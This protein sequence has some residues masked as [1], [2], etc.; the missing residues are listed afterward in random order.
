M[1]FEYRANGVTQTKTLERFPFGARDFSCTVSPGG[2]RSASANFTD[3]WTGDESPNAGWGLTLFHI[4]DGIFAI[5]YTYDLDGEPTFFVL[6]TS[7]QPDDSFS[8]TIFRQRN[9]TPFLQITDQPASP[10]ADA[11]GS[12][13]L[14]FSDGDSASF[15]YT[16][17]GVSQ[18]KPI[19]R[20]VVGSR[21]AECQAGP[22]GG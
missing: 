3:L 1:R 21:P 19:A 20:L 12:A 22:A 17:G 11:V 15:S 8:G 14:R 2:D 6:A 13:V 18:T 7:R 4:D 10:A 16:L 9:G 5:W